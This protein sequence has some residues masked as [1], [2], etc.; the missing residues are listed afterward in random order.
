LTSAPRL[1]SA[2]RAA[3]LQRLG[4]ERL[5]VLVVGGGITG[6]GVALDAAARGLSVGL[7]ER[8]DFAAGT[9]SRS[10]KL[11]HGGLRYL[12]NRDFRLVRE[13][14]RERH[15]ILTRLAPHL[16]RPV[17]FLLPLRS[18][19]ERAYFG[20]GVALYD[21]L[22]GVTAALP[23]HRHLGRTA[24]RRAAPALR[25]EAALGAIRYFDAQMDDARY[26]LMLLR[27][28][29]AHGAAAASRAVV[30]GFIGSERIE[31][32]WL[33][34]RESGT[35]LEAR[36]RV[37]VVAAGV[38]SSRLEQ[39][40]DVA[41]PISI[42]AS[43][44]VHILVPRERLELED[45]L[46]VRT[47]RS[48]LL[49][50]PWHGQWLIGTTDTPYTDELDRPTASS[51]DVSYLLERANA[52]LRH[53]LTARDVTAVFAG[54][55]PLI[56]NGAKDTAKLS[57]EHVIRRP[58]AGLLTVAGGKY[59]TYR[60]MAAETV[61]AAAA[62]LERR[63]ERSPT[64]AIP[65][66]GAEGVDTARRELQR[67]GLSQAAQE[68]LLDR[69]GALATEVVAAAADAESPLTGEPGALRAEA[70]YAVTHEGARSLED[71]F[72]RRTRVALEAAD[73]GLAAARDVAELLGRELGWSVERTA[74]EIATYRAWVE[75]ERAGKPAGAPWHP[76]DADVTLVT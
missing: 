3:A 49:V 70:A 33:E 73:A 19:R 30:S 7:V 34:D 4:S 22:G 74:A 71:V 39:L 11:I 16:V 37:T 46:I 20:A 64:D 31:G 38:W 32:V 23:R 25:D 9:S 55:R 40:A 52:V 17:P 27:T 6:I 12:E 63:V 18:R 42:R 10:T 44:G 69:Y 65:L 8:D 56:D 68:R 54:L 62:E 51:A 21:A 50:V 2:A 13:A 41:A 29:V 60:A 15:L 72:A 53:P 76:A 57:R 45:A 59:T 26:A 36:A 48:V 43:K 5:D 14:L 66:V 28:A 1:D 67:R 24:T 35:E 58:K 75:A 47:E 61:D